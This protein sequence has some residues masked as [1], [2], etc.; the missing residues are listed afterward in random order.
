MP[1]PLL[2]Y[3]PFISKDGLQLNGYLEGD[4]T[5][6]GRFGTTLVNLGDINKDGFTGKETNFSFLFLKCT[7]GHKPP[8]KCHVTF[9]FKQQDFCGTF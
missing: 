1:L 7:E 6:G 5:V 9:S 2:I 4:D 8:Q 3:F